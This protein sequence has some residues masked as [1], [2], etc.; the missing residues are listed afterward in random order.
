MWVRKTREVNYPIG[1]EVGCRIEYHNLGE[2]KV[3]AV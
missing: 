1:Q 3:A 2:T